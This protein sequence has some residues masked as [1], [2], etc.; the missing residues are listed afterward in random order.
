[1]WES[2]NTACYGPLHCVPATL[3]ETLTTLHTAPNTCL[4][5]L[6]C[7]SSF[8]EPLAPP[9]CLNLVTRELSTS[10]PQPT[11]ARRPSTYP[12]VVGSAAPVGSDGPRMAAGWARQA[13]TAPTNHQIGYQNPRRRSM[14][15]HSCRIRHCGKTRSSAQQ[16]NK[17]IIALSRRPTAWKLGSR[18]SGSTFSRPQPTSAHAANA[19]QAPTLE[20]SDQPL[21]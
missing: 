19:A 10:T 5:L 2:N 13:H 8:E 16:P 4:L 14:Q 18:A 15:A 17:H 11:S 6:H 21:M 1:M 12:R 3:C 9:T 7:S 20:W